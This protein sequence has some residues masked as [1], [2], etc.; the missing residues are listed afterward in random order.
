MGPDFRLFGGSALEFIGNAV[1]NGPM[2]QVV[3]RVPIDS[4]LSTIDWIASDQGWTLMRAS[5]PIRQQ[6]KAKS[7]Q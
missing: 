4:E 3:G 5:P 2:G 7:E 1:G 6:I